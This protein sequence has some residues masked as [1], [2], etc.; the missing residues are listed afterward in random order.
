MKTVLANGQPMEVPDEAIC[1]IPGPGIK[2]EAPNHFEINGTNTLECAKNLNGLKALWVLRSSTFLHLFEIIF[3]KNCGVT[4]PLNWEELQAASH[5]VQHIIGMIVL[6]FEARV[7]RGEKIFLR[8]PETHLHPQQCVSLMTLV[9]A[10]D[11]LPTK[12]N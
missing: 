3:D 11:K 6:F 12:P 1:L 10:L 9:N 2:V 8:E 7:E 4:A 5:D